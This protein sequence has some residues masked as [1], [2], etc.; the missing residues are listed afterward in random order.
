MNCMDLVIVLVVG[1]R[2]FN[3]FTLRVMSSMKFYSF[4][5]W[6]RD[7]YFGEDFYY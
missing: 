6:E 2:S 5:L 7:I 4:C 1:L 3:V